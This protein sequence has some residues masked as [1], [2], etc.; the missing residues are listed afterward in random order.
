ME[1]GWG[2]YSGQPW[3]DQQAHGW[4]RLMIFGP[5][6][7]RLKWQEYKLRFNSMVNDVILPNLLPIAMMVA[8]GIGI[9]GLKN[10]RGGS[11][12]TG[13]F[14]RNNIH[15]PTSFKT[16]MK[17][18]ASKTAQGTGKGIGKLVSLP[19]KSPAHLGVTAAALIF[20]AFGLKRF[21]DAYGEDGQEQYFRGLTNYKA[22]TEEG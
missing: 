14:I 6:N 21:Q 22:T 7:L 4:K 3:M 17:Q 1:Y 15:V 2:K 19:F 16:G 12:A 18:V 11:K 10:I 5:M 8:G 13:H 9:V 20:G